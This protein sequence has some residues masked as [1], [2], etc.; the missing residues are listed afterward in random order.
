MDPRCFYCGRP[1]GKCDHYE[2]EKD[3]PDL[4][5]EAKEAIIKSK[6]L[7]KCDDEF[8]KL[9]EEIINEIKGEV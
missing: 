4:S 3:F 9:Y 7:I 8:N 1:T 6:F 2:V 5:I